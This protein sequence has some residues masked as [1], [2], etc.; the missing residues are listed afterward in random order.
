MDDFANSQCSKHVEGVRRGSYDDFRALYDM[1]AGNLH[2]FVFSLTHSEA[3]TGDIVQETFLKVW[4]TRESLR[5]DLSFKAYLFRI[6]RNKIIDEFRRRMANPLFEEYMDHCD[7]SRDEAERIGDAIDFDEFNRRLE[8]AKRKLTP[9]QREIF[10]MNKMQGLPPREI[11]SVF[12]LSEQTVYNQ[13]STAL[14]ILRREMGSL[15][16]LFLLLFR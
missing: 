1:F 5:S 16:V 8:Q 11:A 9:R 10:E 2:G 6:A 13:L 12:G 3:L 7:R 4:A 15:V 14:R